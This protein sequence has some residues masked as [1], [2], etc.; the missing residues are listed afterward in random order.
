MTGA[1]T[2]DPTMQYHE[3]YRRKV[4]RCIHIHMKCR[5]LARSSHVSEAE[6][7]VEAIRLL[8]KV[9]VYT[10]PMVSRKIIHTTIQ[11]TEHNVHVQR[12]NYEMRFQGHSEDARKLQTFLH[13]KSLFRVPLQMTLFNYTQKYRKLSLLGMR[14][15]IHICFEL[16]ISNKTKT[17]T[18]KL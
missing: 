17:K 12:P 18:L 11:D 1:R 4:L 5:L 16:R 2:Y 13:D 6:V 3:E 10:V 7:N 8:S 15:H 9:H 14:N